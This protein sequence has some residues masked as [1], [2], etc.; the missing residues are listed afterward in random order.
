M[1]NYGITDNINAKIAIGTI[2]SH[3]DAVG[4][5]DWTYLG[6]RIQ[7]NPLYYVASNSDNEEDVT[8]LFGR[9]SKILCWIWKAMVALTLISMIRL[10]TTML[11]VVHC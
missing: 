5:L 7:K 2:N 1:E 8:L 4:Y 3:S 10:V 11:L 6:R 9:L